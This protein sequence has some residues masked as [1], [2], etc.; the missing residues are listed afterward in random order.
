MSK[1]LFGIFW[2]VL[3]I[4]CY[5]IAAAGWKFMF[6]GSLICGAVGCVYAIF[7]YVVSKQKDQNGLKVPPVPFRHW[8]HL[9]TDR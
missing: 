5:L 7:G 6:Y 2:M 4:Y 3:G 1:I 8:G 9:V